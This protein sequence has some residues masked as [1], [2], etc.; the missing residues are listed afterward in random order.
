MISRRIRSVPRP[1]TH[2]TQGRR[3]NASGRLLGSRGAARLH[4]SRWCAQRSRCEVSSGPL[5]SALSYGHKPTGQATSEDLRKSRERMQGVIKNST[6]GAQKK[7][8]TLNTKVLYQ[9]NHRVACCSLAASKKT[10][11]GAVPG[12]VGGTCRFSDVVKSSQ[13]CQQWSSSALRGTGAGERRSR[14]RS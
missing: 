2:I 14:P 7:R 8:H 9:T 1:L 12:E 6:Y 3:R 11:Q 5:G 4:G 10:T 13:P